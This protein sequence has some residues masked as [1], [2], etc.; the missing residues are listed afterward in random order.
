MHTL[1]WIL[2]VLL[3][4]GG[5]VS[6]VLPVLPGVLLVFAGLF[7]AAWADGFVRVGWITLAV[8]GALTALSFVL[9]ALAQ[10]AGAKRAGASRQAVAGAVI[11]SVAGIFFG[12]IGIFAG[13]FLG[14]AAGEFLANRDLVKAGRVGYGTLLGIVLGA[15]LKIALA[16]AMI[17]L[18]VTV[19]LIG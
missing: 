16:L 19:Y 3:V 9:D 11:G 14:A 7:T 8:L 2:A 6:L 13:P 17:G 12:I 5:L 1:L 10:A 15:A 18:F 4:L